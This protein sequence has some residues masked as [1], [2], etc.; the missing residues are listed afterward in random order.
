VNLDDLEIH[1]FLTYRLAR[2]HMRLNAQAIRILKRN[3]DLTLTQWRVIALLAG[4]ECQSSSDIERQIDMDKGQISRTI[5]ALSDAGYV[6]FKT[7][8]TDHRK[9]N[10]KLTT[11]AK[12]IYNQ[13]LPI[14]R[15]RQRNLIAHLDNH[16]ITALYSALD[17]L[18]RAAQFSEDAV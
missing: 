18:E 1:Q 3:A 11:K 17:K 14:M 16:E 7:D 4:T 10:L 9:S 8:P 6:K 5:H 2:T 13:T 15:D 12:K